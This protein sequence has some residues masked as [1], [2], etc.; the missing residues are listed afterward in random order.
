MR[1]TQA[2]AKNKITSA[3]VAKPPQTSAF[4]TTSDSHLPA[5]DWAITSF[6]VPFS[7]AWNKSVINVS[8]SA[9]VSMFLLMRSGKIWIESSSGCKG[10]PVL[11]LY[12]LKGFEGFS[13]QFFVMYYMLPKRVPKLKQTTRHN[14]SQRA[15]LVKQLQMTDSLDLTKEM[16]TWS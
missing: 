9:Q 13:L 16:I 15:I 12:I 2:Q 3:R 14:I 6:D 10:A 5:I 1:K 4:K 7:N 11:I 8:Q